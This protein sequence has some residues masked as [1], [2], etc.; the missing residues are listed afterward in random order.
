VDEVKKGR[1][2]LKLK[3]F[4]G[5]GWKVMLGD[6]KKKDETPI[7][8]KHSEKKKGGGKREN[9]EKVYPL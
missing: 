7:Y 9:S 3:Y 6:E 8:F 4:R 2:R 1:K 5:E